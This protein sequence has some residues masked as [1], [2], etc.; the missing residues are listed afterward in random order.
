MKSLINDLFTRLSEKYEY[1]VGL[2]VGG[3]K[4]HELKLSESKEVL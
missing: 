2:Y 4:E 1:N 3:M